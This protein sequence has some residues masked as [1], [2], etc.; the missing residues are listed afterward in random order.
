MAKR[1]ISVLIFIILLF[2][3]F[4]QAQVE[5]YDEPGMSPYRETIGSAEVEHIDQFTEEL[6]ISH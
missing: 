6:T 1:N 2:P 3:T 5:V 4:L